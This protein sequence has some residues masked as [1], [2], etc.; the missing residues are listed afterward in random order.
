[1]S[2][3]RDVANILS[4]VSTNM[5]TDA[6]VA[7]SI[8]SHAA[9]ADPHSVYLKESEFNADGKNVVING[10]MDIWQRG[11]S[12]SIAAS[13]NNIYT[14]DRWSIGTGTSQICTVSRQAT[15]DTTNLPNIQYCARVQRNS[16]Q[17]GTATIP[18]TQAIET[19]NSISLMGKTITLSFYARSGANYSATSNALAVQLYTGTGTDQNLWGYTGTIAV[20]NTNAT[21]TTTWQRFIY[22]GTLSS[23]GNE[24][25]FQFN[26]VPTG[27]AGA[28][29]YFE[30]TGVQLELG[31]TATNFSRAGQNI[32][33]E[34][35]ACQRYYFRVNA[36][37]TSQYAIF[38]AGGGNSTT[39]ARTIVTFPVT[40]RVKPTAI[41]YPTLGSNFSIIA[42]DDSINVA[43]TAA[44]IDSN[45][46]DTQSGYILWT[47]SSG[48]V[49][50]RPLVVRGL[51]STGAYL[52]FSAEL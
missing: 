34:L 6:E 15:N 28:N 50:N 10:G 29:D 23:S 18:F 12:I 45:Q 25:G 16:G 30:I 7:S 37:G 14:A 41:D 27:T 8:A 40:M 17:T 46:S 48:V 9:A 35:A 49:A 1:M 19:A 31:S 20:L 13:Q 51:A 42:Y 24:I 32:Q 47:A 3:V 36:F 22:T 44:A 21:L 43:P 2:R 26:H 52:G 11:T 5:A 38:G 4:G 39:Q 33:S